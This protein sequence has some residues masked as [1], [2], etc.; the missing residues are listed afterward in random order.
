MR[1]RSSSEKGTSSVV[2]STSSST[3][4]RRHGEERF[5]REGRRASWK[6]TADEGTAQADAAAPYLPLAPTP[7][8][9]AVAVRAALARG[10]RVAA[11]PAGELRVERVATL[12]VRGA[13]G[14][15][16]VSLYAVAGVDFA[17]QYLWLDARGRL[18]AS[19]DTLT[20][21]IGVVAEGYAAEAPRLVEARKHAE[22]KQLE[23]LAART[24]HR[25]DVPLAIRDVRVFDPLTGALGPASTVHVFRGRVSSVFPASEPVPGDVAVVDGAGG[26]LL[27]ALVDMHS[28]ED[29]W[30]AALQIAGGVTTVRDVGNGEPEIL[31]LDRR[32]AEGDDRQGRGPA[33]GSYLARPLSLNRSMRS[34][35]RS[36][37]RSSGPALRGSGSTLTPSCWKTSTATGLALT[38][39][40]PPCPA[41]ASALPFSLEASFSPCPPPPPSPMLM[42]EMG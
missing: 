14:P 11:V 8:S 4:R 12:E 38:P 9:G 15:R 3:R 5:A 18:F 7:E 22:A 32:V 33:S 41:P 42:S 25:V 34:G 2:A 30:N 23:R 27:P 17:P 40:P 31:E 37:N 39:P 36:R 26:T 20:P 6:T 16:K 1:S 19:L 10:G 29:P 24:R 13:P 35:S 28:H 21:P